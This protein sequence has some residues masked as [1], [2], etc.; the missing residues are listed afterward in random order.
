[1]MSNEFVVVAS[2]WVP[3][4]AHMNTANHISSGFRGGES[5]PVR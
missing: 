5:T 1:M 3:F 4:F 2:W